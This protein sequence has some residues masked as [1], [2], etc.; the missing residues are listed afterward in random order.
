MTKCRLSPVALGLAVGCLGALAVLIVAITTFIGIDSNFVRMLHAMHDG[1]EQTVAGFL[2][3]AL[4]SFLGGF[5][6]GFF[7]GWFYNLFTNCC[8]KGKMQCNE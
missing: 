8:C 2:L 3:A 1:I 6:R 7:I 4:V 5:V